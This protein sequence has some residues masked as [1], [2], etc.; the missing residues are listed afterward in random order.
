MWNSSVAVEMSFMVTHV[1]LMTVWM[2]VEL[3]ENHM[4]I[5]TDKE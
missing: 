4:T 5:Y 1:G 3:C 2:A